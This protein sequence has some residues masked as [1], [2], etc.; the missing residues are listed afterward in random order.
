MMRRLSTLVFDAYGTLFDTDSVVILCERFWPGRGAE[1]ARLWRTTQLQYTWLRTLMRR[2][3]DFAAVTAASLQ[4]ACGALGLPY[5]GEKGGQLCRAYLDLDAYSDVRPALANLRGFN[6]AILSNGTR[7]MLEHVV[8]KNGLTDILPTI[9]SVDD[10]QQYKPAP[11]VYQLAVHRLA[12]PVDAI[13]FVSSNSW[14]AAGA[15]SFGFTTFWVNRRETPFDR[16]G[17][18]PDHEI[19]SLTDL[20]VVLGA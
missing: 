13:G 8:A 1:L 10:I 12:V 19:P 9:L 4:F 15:K 2:H 5:D 14:D 11:E 18:S 6:L 17:V 16:L 20:P 7:T 3:E